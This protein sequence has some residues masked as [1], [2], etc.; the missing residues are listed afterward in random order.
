MKSKDLESSKPTQQVYGTVDRNISIQSLPHSSTSTIKTHKRVVSPRTSGP[1][2]QISVSNPGMRRSSTL[3]IP[4]TIS[5]RGSTSPGQGLRKSPN[6]S[7][8]ILSSSD[9]ITKSGDYFSDVHRQPPPSA[10]K[11]TSNPQEMINNV[12]QSIDSKAIVNDANSKRLSSNYSPQEMIKNLRSSINSKAKSS[13]VG[14]SNQE[15]SPKGQQI[16]NDIRD[17]IDT[18][19]KIVSGSS[20]NIFVG[21]K[22]ESTLRT[23][24]N[25]S[26][27]NLIYGSNDVNNSYSSF[28][29]SFSERASTI[30]DVEAEEGDNEEDEYQEE[31]VEED[32]EDVYDQEKGKEEIHYKETNEGESSNKSEPELK[33][34]DSKA[35]LKRKPPPKL[36]DQELVEPKNT[37]FYI[38]D[39]TGNNKSSDAFSSTSSLANP[40]D[41]YYQ[42]DRNDGYTEESNLEDHNMRFPQFPDVKKRTDSKNNIFK[43]KKVKDID[44]T[45]LLDSD[46]EEEYSHP[47]ASNSALVQP[48]V[49]F[50]TTMREKKRKD[51]KNQFNENKPWKNHNELNYLSDQERKRYEG[52]WA[53]NKGNYMNQVVTRLVGVDYSLIPEVDQ[54]NEELSKKAAKL[55]TN[56]QAQNMS[57]QDNF[58]NLENVELN[59][60]IHGAVVLRIWRRSRLPDAT[61]EQIWSLVDFRHDGTLNKN[62]FLVGMWLVDQCLYGRKLPKKVEPIVWDSLGGIGVNIKKKNRR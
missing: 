40:D 45:L 35:K 15:K 20:P 39:G 23:L 34:I 42:L 29:S 24:S 49:Q 12:K 16:L 62:E 3:D 9:S 51:K 53:S 2:L 48:S 56:N 7:P 25:Q 28:G 17:R 54:E 57:D 58:H 33:N 61:L 5:Q 8:R 37:L 43:K 21:S 30:A 13:Q 59:Q 10:P 41:M 19:M 38:G 18:R 6:H 47:S 50:K 60:L 11:H 14:L 4:G 46:Y 52:V 1:S 32:E 26:D 31:E 55:S 36:M 44:A 27:K 22:A